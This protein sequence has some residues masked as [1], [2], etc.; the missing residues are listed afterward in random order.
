MP[1]LPS[2]SDALPQMG[3]L[4][5]TQ[6]MVWATLF[7]LGVTAWMLAV[8]FFVKWQQQRSLG[9][10]QKLTEV[11]EDLFFAAVTGDEPESLPVIGRRDRRHVL[12]IWCHIGN[13]VAG[14]ALDRLTDLGRRLGLDQVALAILT[15]GGLRLA[16]PSS[17]EVLLALRAAERLQIVAVWEPLKKIVSVGPAPLDRFAARALVAIDAT[18]AAPAIL[19]ALIRQGRWAAHLV[20]DLMEVGVADAVEHYAALLEEVS[21]EA[22]PGLALLLDRCNN[23]ITLLAVRSRLA[24]DQTLDPDALAALLNTLSVVGGEAERKMVSAFSGHE[25]WFVRMRAAQAVGQCGDQRDAA[26][27]ESLLSDPNWYA[28]YHAARAVLAITELGRS[29]LQAF[30]ERTE[31]RFAHDMALH[32]LAEAEAPA[33]R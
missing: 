9:R 24:A 7:F 18:A 26:L 33:L 3:A 11:W 15:P 28:R 30:A 5:S 2:A 25:Q 14:D 10:D 32:V 1:A 27:L 16:N 20:E 4:L 23:P 13:S 22:I 19:P 21:D 12:K 8:V 17:A 6:A 29:Y 31:D